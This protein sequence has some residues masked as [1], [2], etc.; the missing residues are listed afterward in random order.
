MI[1]NSNP[2]ADGSV[3]G[4]EVEHTLVPVRMYPVLVLI[5][6]S[7]CVRIGRT[8]YSRVHVSD[9]CKFTAKPAV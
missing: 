7:G 8:W 5:F 3:S 1:N 9:S 4:K 6:I 2:Y